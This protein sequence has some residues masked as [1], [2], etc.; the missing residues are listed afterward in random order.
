MNKL[1]TSLIKVFSFLASAI[2]GLISII[3]GAMV[4]IGFASI[5]YYVFIAEEPATKKRQYTAKTIE[6][7]R[8]PVLVKKIML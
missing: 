7:L 3:I 8:F 5:I 6:I 2:G 4:L 1:Q